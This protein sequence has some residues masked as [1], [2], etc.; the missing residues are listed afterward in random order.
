MPAIVSARPP[1]KVVKTQVE[2][3]FKHWY[4]IL[5]NAVLDYCLLR[6]LTVLYSPTGRQVVGNTNKPVVP[7]LFLRIYDYP[8]TRYV[9][10]RTNL[11]RCGILG[12]SH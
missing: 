3:H 1:Y 10:R 6:G 7:N 8:G 2:T 12:N 5:F 11:H 9:C 4:A